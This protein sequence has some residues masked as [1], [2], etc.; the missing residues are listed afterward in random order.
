MFVTLS[1]GC[2][3]FD[4]NHG[5]IDMT[6]FG[7]DVPEEYQCIQ[8]FFPIRFHDFDADQPFDHFTRIRMFES[9]YQTMESNYLTITFVSQ[10]SET[11]EACPEPEANHSYE[12]TRSGCVRATLQLN[13]Y[14]EP[15]MLDKLA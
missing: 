14:E 12:I 4:D 1:M 15:T 3:W 11:F 5:S 7:D 6:S 8:N 9:I 13:G 2:S 10:D